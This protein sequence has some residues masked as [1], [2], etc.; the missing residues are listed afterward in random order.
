M[1]YTGR[2]GWQASY[3]DTFDLDCALSP[4]IYTA[5]VKFRDQMDKEWFG[6]PSKVIDYCGYTI[7]ETTDDELKECAEKWKD[8]VDRMIVAFS[9]E[10]DI[11]DYKFEYVCVECSCDIYDHDRDVW[12]MKPDNMDE[13]N[14]YRADEEAY[15]KAKDEGLKL[16]GE[17]YNCLWW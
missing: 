12:N 8:I 4:I 7:G 13:Y 10:P 9:K 17:F 3:Q 6:V 2:K 14:R 11:N 5:L 1:R 16:F 15:R